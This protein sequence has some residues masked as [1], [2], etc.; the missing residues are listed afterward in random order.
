MTDSTNQIHSCLFAN[1]V[2][3]QAKASMVVILKSEGSSESPQDCMYI[4]TE[5][6]KILFYR[7]KPAS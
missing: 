4:C 7:E 5:A 6:Y 3:S 2:E 1:G